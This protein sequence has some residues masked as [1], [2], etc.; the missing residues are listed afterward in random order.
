MDDTIGASVSHGQDMSV[1]SMKLEEDYDY[2]EDI[3]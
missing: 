2:Y 1:D 3:I